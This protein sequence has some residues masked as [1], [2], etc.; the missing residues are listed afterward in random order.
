MSSSPPDGYIERL[1]Q[2]CAIDSP[3]GYTPGLDACATLLAH[4]AEKG[5]VE[6]DRPRTAQSFCVPKAEIAAA[7]YDLSINRYKE[8][9]HEAVDHRA[10][11]EIIAELKGLEAEIAKGLDELETML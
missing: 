5:G 1:R 8:V 11:K 9:V 6:R 4:W 10:P 2:L 3:T 7:D